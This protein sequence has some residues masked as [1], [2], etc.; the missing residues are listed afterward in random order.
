MG[1]D[2]NDLQTIERSPTMVVPH[3]H[4][5]RVA[6]PDRRVGQIFLDL[7][8]SSPPALLAPTGRVRQSVQGSIAAGAVGS[9]AAT[10]Y[11]SK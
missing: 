3:P 1:L 11:K 9:G 5:P 4:A 8:S 10:P 2:L 6:R 7:Q